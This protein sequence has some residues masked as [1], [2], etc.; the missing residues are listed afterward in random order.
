MGKGVG[1]EG[2]TESQVQVYVEITEDLASGS[3]GD[4]VVDRDEIVLMDRGVI[5]VTAN[6]SKS[7]V[8]KEIMDPSNKGNGPKSVAAHLHWIF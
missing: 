8:G 3:T 2:T 7:Q 4:T 1:T 5:S 6:T